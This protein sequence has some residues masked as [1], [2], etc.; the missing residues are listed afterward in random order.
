MNRTPV[1]LCLPALALLTSCGT[2]RRM[3]NAMASGAGNVGGYVSG[4]ARKLGGQ[5][6]RLWPWKPGVAAPDPAPVRDNRR[7][8]QADRPLT[9]PSFPT[10]GSLVAESELGDDATR[11]QAT[12]VH[13][14]GGWEIKGSSIAYHLDADGTSPRILKA[15]GT[16]AV[17]STSNGDTASA[18]AI[19]YRLKTGVLVFSGDPVLKTGGQSIRG[20][21]PGTTIRIHVPS[22]AM[23]VD[24]PANY[25]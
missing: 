21:G 9:P 24:G 3:S 18:A 20:K 6:A 12:S 16:P 4:G 2:A 13:I 7:D 1:Y 23:T 19:H 22:G 14:P 11:L 25:E 17:A 8:E 5:A 15:T 10:S